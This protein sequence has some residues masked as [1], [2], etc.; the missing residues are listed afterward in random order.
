M[1][2][3]GAGAKG[4]CIVGPKC[5]MGFGHMGPLWTDRQTLDEKITFPHLRLRAVNMLE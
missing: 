3:V 4:P 2:G 5:I 1:A